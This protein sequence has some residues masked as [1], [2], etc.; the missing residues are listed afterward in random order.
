[1]YTVRLHFFEKAKNVSMHI[2]NIYLCLAI[3]PRLPHIYWSTDKC[4]TTGSLRGKV[5]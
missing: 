3:K 5:P 1:M 4:L 2:P